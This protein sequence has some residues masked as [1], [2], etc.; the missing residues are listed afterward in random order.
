MPAITHAQE[1]CARN[2][3]EKFNA[4]LSQFLAQVKW[5]LW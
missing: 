1:T 5:P 3:R 4:S 2:F